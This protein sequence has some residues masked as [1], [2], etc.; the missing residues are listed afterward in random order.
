MAQSVIGALR[1]NLGLDSAQFVRGARQAQT[2]AQRMSRQFAVAGAA[3]SAVGTGIAIAVR[4]QL[5][6]FDD[7]AKTS[8]R[9]GVPVEALS[10]LRHAADLSGASIQGM[11]R[12]LRNVSREMVNNAEK[13]TD[14][15]VAVRD[16]DG[17]M[18]PVLDVFEDAAQVISQM[19]DGA[20]KTALAMQL[21]GERAGPE[22]IP[23][24]NQGRDG[25]RAMR[26]EA[27][28]LGLTVSTDAAQAAER[29]N[30][31][32]TRLGGQMQGVVRIVTAELA[33]VL[34]RISNVVVRAAERFQGMSAPMRRF[35]AIG[36]GLTVV[37]GPVLLG[38][39]AIVAMLGV[40]ISPIGLAIFAI[41]AM[42]GAVAL[43]AANFD[44]LK[45]RFPILERAAGYGQRVADAWGGLPSIKWALLIPVV[46]WAS[47]IPG[48]RWLSFVRVLR[49][50]T[51]VSG[52]SWAALAGGLRWGALITPLLWGARFIPVIGWA[53]TAGMLAW[54][55][56][57]E[58]LGWDQF[59]ST[60]NWRDWIPE[61]NW[62][63]ILGGGT[64][65]S[66][67]RRI[68][69]DTSEGLAAGIRSGQSS[70]EQ[71][72]D[73][74]AGAA[75]TSSRSR[76]ETRSPSR[77]FMRIGRDLM[78]GLGLGIEQGAQVPVDA[79]G[80]VS[81]N[82]GSAAEAA[83]ERMKGVAQTLSGL[84]MA[85]TRGADAAKQ[86]LG[87]LLSRAA[88]ALANRA[89]MSLLGGGGGKKGG[90]GFMGF[91]SGLLS[92][93][94][95]GY[96]GMRARTGGLDGKGGFMAMMH[97]NETVID[98]TKGQSLGGS[99]QLTITLDPGLRAEMQGE[100]QG[101]AIQYTSAAIQQY[102]AQALPQRMQQIGNDPRRIG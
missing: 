101:I 71:A 32:L 34:E 99:G 95:G 84:F 42:A 79:I 31:N 28:R 1:V 48:L 66:S 68:G 82:L 13:Y 76:L 4:G 23:M 102:D 64:A 6:A 36:A 38:L 91:L 43:A 7:L 39:S 74:V 69:Q 53:V 67:A 63:N 49:W 72:A 9:I 20:D 30:D 5:G 78:N 86:A 70:V 22:L 85:A 83:Q 11:E 98:H 93:D 12:G 16:V 62:S 29:F 44:T 26:E 77:V 60:I 19:E 50:S 45:D 92:F 40:I 37:L 58:P 41:A 27:D 90:G 57:I 89:F 75:E 52:I 55:F 97:P 18:R 65:G 96:T 81:A 25:I 61:I 17:N 54:S 3:V 88:E 35:I 94:G 14:L 87:Q 24:L 46:R 56:L 47:F 15:G 59:I 33:P 73:A 10:Q 8:Q 100:M 2:T 21:F 80:E 51:F